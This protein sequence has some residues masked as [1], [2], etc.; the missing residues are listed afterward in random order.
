MP[1][2][3]LERRSRLLVK[4]LGL[5][6]GE[7]FRLGRRLPLGRLSAER[8]RAASGRLA[9]PRAPSRRLCWARLPGALQNRAALRRAYPC[10][11]LPHKMGLCWARLCW[12]RLCWARLCWARL[13]WARLCWARLC[14]A[15]LCWARLCWARLCWARLCWAR[16]CWAPFRL[17]TGRPLGLVRSTGALGGSAGRLVRLARHR[18]ARP[19][20]AAPDKLEGRL[21]GLRCRRRLRRRRPPR[22]PRRV[23]RDIRTSSSCTLEPAVVLCRVLRLLLAAA[24]VVVQKV[25]VHRRLGSACRAPTCTA[26]LWHVLRCALRVLRHLVLL[27]GVGCRGDVLGRRFCRRFF[28]FRRLLQRRQVALAGVHLCRLLA[29]QVLFNIH[30]PRRVACCRGGREPRRCPLQ[31]RPRRAKER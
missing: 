3:C 30:K 19:R 21:L 20:C 23:A 24:G 9:S 31:R 28:R 17:R 25:H 1:R 12:P 27:G 26:R 18:D 22:R 7:T 14:W 2:P 15:R 29:G 4:V 8:N 16:L 6:F 10:R 5:H 13:C 11:S